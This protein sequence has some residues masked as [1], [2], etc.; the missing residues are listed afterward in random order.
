MDRAALPVIAVAALLT[1]SGCRSGTGQHSALASAPTPCASRSASAGAS[2]RAAAEPLQTK[3]A[4]R[5]EELPGGSL[6]MTIGDVDATPKDPKY[7]RSNDCRAPAGQTECD[8]IRIIKVHGWWCTT[9][10]SSVAQ[11]GEIVLGGATPRATIH[12]A[13]FRTHCSGR[14]ARIR[15]HHE[16]QRDSR[17][18]WRA[19]SKRRH[20]PWTTAQHQAHG[21]VS[22][23]CPR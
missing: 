2:P 7:V 5:A 13:G 14:H 16:I 3:I 20:T 15:Q 10:V 6:R 19:Y 11:D 4:W 17:S 12:S 1:V 22:A 23:P 8:N 9:T 18:G 21:T